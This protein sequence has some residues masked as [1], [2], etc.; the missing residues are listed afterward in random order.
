[1]HNRRIIPGRPAALLITLLAGACSGDEPASGG[2]STPAVPEAG[3]PNVLLITLDTTRPDFLSTYGDRGESTPNFDALAADG[4]RF[5]QAVSASAVTPV[6]HATILTGQFPYGHGLRV[7][8]GAGGFR[9]P[10]DV[11]TLATQF[12]QAGYRTAAIHSAFPVSGYFGLTRDY[13]F[14]DSFDGVMQGE[15]DELS[16]W[17][18]EKLQRRAGESIGHALKWIQQEDERPFFLWLHLWDPHD[19]AILPPK[20][21]LGGLKTDASGGFHP[22]QIYAREIA[23]VDMHVGRLVAKLKNSGHWDETLTAVIADHGEGLLDGLERHGWFSHRMLYREQ[24]HVPLL[25][26]LPSALS[27]RGLTCPDL[28]RSADVAPTLLDYCG[29]P[30]PEGTHGR[31]LRALIEGTPDEPRIAYAD[32]VNAFDSNA[33]MVRKRPDAAFLFSVQEGPWKLVWR[34]HM[35]ERSEL[36]NLT[37]DPHEETNLWTSETDVRTRLLEDL[38][39][40]RPWVLEPFAPLDGEVQDVA[41]ALSA[42]GYGGSDETEGLTWT[43]TCP[44]HLARRDDRSGRCPDCNRRLLPVT[45]WN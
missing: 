7:L 37:A 9:L 44:E 19:S 29:L 45:T 6:S 32:Q 24:I 26:R 28:V 17:P 38:S 22:E 5:D 18:V 41:G 20:K 15:S 12:K 2:S 40:R 35:I 8:A 21:F 11:P 30:V 1:M 27:Q 14:V 13:D 34:P 36:F 39:D 23:F 16:T 31:S 43:W 42:L 10:D 4:I 3:A 33:G 25:L